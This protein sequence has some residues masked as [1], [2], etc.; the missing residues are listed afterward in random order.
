MLNKC[1]QVSK[2][3][4][5]GIGLIIDSTKE[6]MNEWFKKAQRA[7]GAQPP[8]EHWAGTA[9]TRPETWRPRASEAAEPEP[10]DAAWLLTPRILAAVIPLQS[11]WCIPPQRF[12]P[13]SSRCR[14][15]LGALCLFIRH[16]A[17]SPPFPFAFLPPFCLHIC[18][19]HPAMAAEEVLQTVDHY[20]AEIERLTKELS[21]TTH[22]K[23]QAAEYGLVVLEEKLTL[24]QQ[25][26]ELEAEY[27]GLKQELEQLKEL[28][29]PVLQW[30]HILLTLDLG[31]KPGGFGQL[32]ISTLPL[33]CSLA[34]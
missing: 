21:E 16:F 3:L 12:R 30:D 6:E 4:R 33:I 26:D 9:V 34:V 25:Y 2:K 17:S 8:A 13:C 10:D 29:K 11:S 31:V 14:P 27:D 1:Y 23:I 24:K 28:E 22:E 18:L 5:G 7:G 20:K 32:G 19:R 15:G